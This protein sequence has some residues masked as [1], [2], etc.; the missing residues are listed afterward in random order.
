MRKKCKHNGHKWGKIRTRQ[1]FTSMNKYEQKYQCCKRWFCSEINEKSRT[2][3]EEYTSMSLP[4]SMWEEIR[5]KGY[6]VN[7]H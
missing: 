2:H 6:V 4:S 7:K 5:K 3:I 1:I